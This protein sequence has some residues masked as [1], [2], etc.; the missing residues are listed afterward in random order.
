MVLAGSPGRRPPGGTALASATE[1]LS[2]HGLPAAAPVVLGGT[3]GALGA[4][5]RPDR[6]VCGRGAMPPFRVMGARVLESPGPG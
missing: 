1:G 5:R 4:K 2:G 3:H 6:S